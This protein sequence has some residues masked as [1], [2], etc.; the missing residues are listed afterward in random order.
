M[1]VNSKCIN[2]K[3]LI[4]PKC[5]SVSEP[6]LL[7]IRNQQIQKSPEHRVS[8]KTCD[9]HLNLIYFYFVLN[10]DPPNSF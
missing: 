7:Q 9:L 1:I 10:T 4:Q 8:S 2:N 6:R 5:E 3:L